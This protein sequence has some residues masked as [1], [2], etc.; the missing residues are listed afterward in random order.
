M[1]TEP[2]AESALRHEAEM[3]TARLVQ[4]RRDL[5]R[6]PEL[7]LHLPLTQQYVLDALAGL[8]LTISTGQQQSSVLARLDGTGSG[9]TILLRADMDALPVD[10]P[11]GVPFRSRHPGVM[12]ACGHDAHTAML[13]GAVHLLARRR[14]RFAGTVLFAFQPG[15]EGHGGARILLDEGAVDGVDEAYALHIAPPLPTGLLATRAGT[16]MAS[17]DPFE[18]VVSGKGG[19]GSAAT[20]GGAVTA[21]AA[22]TTAIADLGQTMVKAAEPGIVS[23]GVLRAGAAPN[24]QP[25]RASLS[26]TLRAYTD[27]A[28]R[29]ARERLRHLVERVCAEH[30]VA[31]SVAWPGPNAPATVN[32]EAAYTRACAAAQHVAGEHAVL[33]LQEPVAAAEDFG[34]IAEHVPAAMVFVGA[35]AADAGDVHAPTLRID[36]KCLPIGAALYAAIV[37]ERDGPERP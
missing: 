23:V 1:I 25:T 28:R 22:V 7:G 35:G 27:G 29:D 4:W 36:E 17:S 2:T 16:I 33:T 21:A 11:A 34:L 20:R 8:P 9:P 24:V 30:G 6:R 13:L 15:E 3:M 26:G 19:H 5:H 31:G 32:A 14:D 18:V 10:E 37:E 12:H